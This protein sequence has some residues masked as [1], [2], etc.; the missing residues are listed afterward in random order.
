MSGKLVI[1]CAPSG[2][3][4]TTI[5]QHL[6]KSN[7]NL[8]FSISATT[9]KKREGIE[10]HGKHYYFLTEEDFCQRID[11]GKVAEW[12]EVYKGTYYGTLKS[13]IERLWT[14]GKTVLFDV[15]VKGGLNL[16]RAYG[17]QALSIFVK[18]PSV[19][20]LEQRLRSRGTENEESLKKRLKKVKEEME[21]AP[22]FDETLVNDDLE[23]SFVKAQ[24]LVDK[25]LHSSKD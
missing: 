2:S 22:F 24:N 15:D 20:V 9:R 19:E 4:K 10:E 21:Y 17:D 25:F 18:V 11:D 23:V 1:F 14:Q 13:E 8:G 3:G 7:S 5:V 16:K 12:E 6:L